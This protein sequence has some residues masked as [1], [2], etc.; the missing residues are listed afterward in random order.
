MDFGTAKSYRFFFGVG[1]DSGNELPSQPA[2]ESKDISKCGS[3]RGFPAD[4][5]GK[6]AGGWRRVADTSRQRVLLP[7]RDVARARRVRKDV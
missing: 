5:R 4:S 3:A 6:H 2:V 7:L 1:T